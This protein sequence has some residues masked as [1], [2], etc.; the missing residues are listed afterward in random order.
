MNNYWNNDKF[1]PTRPRKSNVISNWS[2][3]DSEENFIKNPKDGYTKDSIIYRYNSAGYRTNE[4]NFIDP[5]ILCLGCSFTEG[6]GVNVEQAWPD[7]LAKHFTNY[8]VYNLGIE[9]S[10]GDSVPRMLAHIQDLFN[11]Q[12]IFI[13][14]PILWRFEIY[15][16]DRVQSIRHD[17][18]DGFS[19]L[20]LS[21]SNFLNIRQRN[22]LLVSLLGQKYNYKIL[23]YNAEDFPARVD[24]GRDA[25]PG[26]KSH[27]IMANMFLNKYHNV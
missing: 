1:I 22:K 24:E 9:G 21:D 6:I 10:S 12:L 25:H 18:P 8:N 13:L 5:A 11:V 26:P 14:W 17:T 3:S 2:D 16:E 4:F 19:K 15:H 20:M 23:D 27:N 7:I